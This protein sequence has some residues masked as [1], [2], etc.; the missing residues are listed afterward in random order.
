MVLLLVGLGLSDADTARSG[1]VDRDGPDGLRPTT[2]VGLWDE[3]I[4]AER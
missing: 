2:A 4:D 3:Y 1:I